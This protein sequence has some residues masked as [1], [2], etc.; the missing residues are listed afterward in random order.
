MTF[1]SPPQGPSS[2]TPVV[3]TC[4]YSHVNDA[5]HD[6]DFEQA[7]ELLRA[8]GN[9]HRVAIIT[10]LASGPRC[11]HELTE[12]LDVGQPL[13]S[14]HLKVLRSARLLTSERRGKEVVYTLADEHVSHI[15]GDAISHAKE[16][17]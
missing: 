16:L 14:Q 8:L 3:H 12:D 15:V 7:A 6:A 17:T 11:V 10:L 9:R 5:R 2:L 1:V 4:E 13:V